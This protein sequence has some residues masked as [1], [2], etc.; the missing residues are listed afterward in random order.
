M[1]VDL[2]EAGVTPRGGEAQP[3]A[4]GG[5]EDTST[6]L[7]TDERATD[8]L[9]PS[10]EKVSEVE[11]GEKVS[12]PIT[13]V[14]Q[15]DVDQQ[16]KEEQQDGGE[17]EKLES[18]V[19]SGLSETVE[20]ETEG[21]TERVSRELEC[22]EMMPELAVVRGRATAA[23]SVSEPLQREAEKEAEAQSPL[24]NESLVAVYT[25]ESGAVDH[26][27][28]SES[29][30][31]TIDTNESALVEGSR[32][33]P[34]PTD[35]PLP[36]S[37]TAR[38]TP[39]HSPPA[40][41]SPIPPPSSPLT[42]PSLTPV[43]T[44]IPP[45]APAVQ[46]VPTAVTTTVQSVTTAV[47]TTAVQSVTTAPPQA[48][49]HLPSPPPLLL[50]PPSSESEP[51]FHTPSTAIDK[52]SSVPN[53][54][55][56]SPNLFDATPLEAQTPPSAISPTVVP[57]Q[58]DIRS[59]G[60][61]PVAPPTPDTGVASS[62]PGDDIPLP[63][64][65]LPP[66][67]SAGPSLVIQPSSADSHVT[68]TTT[69]TAPITHLQ[70]GTI[71]SPLEL[72]P[73]LNPET[74]P[75]Q[76]PPTTP[77]TALQFSTSETST[78]DEAL[79]RELCSEATEE[80]T[81]AALA[82]QLGLEFLEQSFLGGMDL[83][84]LVQSPFESHPPSLG[85]GELSSSEPPVVGSALPPLLPVD[86]GIGDEG[87]GGTP[88][89]PDTTQLLSEALT[90]LSTPSTPILPPSSLP[91]LPPALFPGSPSLLPTES[92]VQPTPTLTSS[93]LTPHSSPF[94]PHT[95][96]ILTPRAP[97]ISSPLTPEILPDLDSLSSVN[98]ADLLEGIPPEI[99]ET[100]QALAQFDQ[101]NYHS[102]L[103]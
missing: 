23:S 42:V 38:L 64:E 63:S 7:S 62:S 102:P 73:L 91:P 19:G 87:G 66:T 86:P 11:E 84:Q 31:K 25:G 99:A 50:I 26:V 41:P 68:P 15:K 65:H 60:Q 49:A 45:N 94:T 40:P 96:S 56:T 53:S 98:E 48:P 13:E 46:N 72:L 22:E 4:A 59:E 57:T 16:M 97:S 61:L 33:R 55:S 32:K 27:K 24:K 1:L 20:S 100:I 10:Q 18:G 58:L 17:T 34:C 78:T 39:P 79:I 43:P 95:P 83:I 101:Q 93:I 2:L 30:V 82:S 37:K 75:Q 6:E 67:S 47:T 9:K 21:K 81:A 76:A 89:L 77:S 85:D 44:T 69:T 51:S 103:Q 71:N 35:L 12:T 80:T 14:V 36:P 88:V 92:P 3:T 8:P 74:A 29:V 70:V 52:D 28:E 5:T 54:T 90:S